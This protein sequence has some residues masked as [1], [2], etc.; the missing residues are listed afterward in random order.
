MPMAKSVTN[1][2]EKYTLPTVNLERDRG[3]D[4]VSTYSHYT[5]FREEELRLTEVKSMWR[6]SRVCQMAPE[7]TAK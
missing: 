3:K 6:S 1:R 5:H 7:S 2:S 4:V